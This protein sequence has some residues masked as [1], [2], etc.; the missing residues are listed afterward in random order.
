MLHPEEMPELGCNDYRMCQKEFKP[1]HIVKDNHGVFS[2]LD[3]GEV[4]T[5]QI[6]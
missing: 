5:C 4:A 1:F 2:Y 3:A 6:Q